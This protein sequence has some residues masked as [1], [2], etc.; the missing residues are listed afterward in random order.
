M[1]DTTKQNGTAIATFRECRGLNRD[2]LAEKLGISYPYLAN[3][4]NEHKDASPALVQRIAIEL[5]VPVKAICRRAIY[6]PTAAASA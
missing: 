2:Q 5:D 3:V 4:E 6:T 1:A